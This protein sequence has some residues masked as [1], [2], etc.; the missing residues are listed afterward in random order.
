MRKLLKKVFVG[1]LVLC[2]LIQVYRPPRTNPQED[3]VQTIFADAVVWQDAPKSIERACI[4]CH[5]YRTRWPW[6][7]QIA[8]VS[9]LVARD[10]REGREHMNLS[11]WAAYDTP[12]KMA[13]LD[14]I[15]KEVKARAMPLPIYVPLHPE[16]KLS[17]AERAEICAWAE[18]ARARLSV[19]ASEQ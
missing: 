4:D 3:S 5:T 16:A 17:D 9:W 12:Q 2:A 7:S 1:V 13:L 10:V 11:D 6:Y 18:R 14:D 15:C 8:P 19:R